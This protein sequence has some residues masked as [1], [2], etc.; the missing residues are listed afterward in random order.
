MPNP[1]WSAAGAVILALRADAAAAPFDLVAAEGSLSGKLPVCE[2]VK[3]GRFR[4]TLSNV[5]S[6]VRLRPSR[7]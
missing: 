6:S 7:M 2:A 5:P 4:E 3:D 1:L